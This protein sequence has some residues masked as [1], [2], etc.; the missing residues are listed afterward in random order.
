MTHRLIHLTLVA[1][2]LATS[3]HA[4]TLEVGENKEFK[5]PSGAAA[6]A[7][8]GD[9]VQ[10]QP[11]EYFDC[12]IWSANKLVVEGVGDPEK[13]VVTDKACQGKALFITVGEG[14]TIRNLTLTRARVPDG[15]GAGIR[16]EGKDLVVDGVRFVNNQNG[17]L[18]GTTGGSMVVRNSVFERNGACDSACAHGLYV[19]N[20]DLLQVEHSRFIG[21]KRGHHIKSRA[22]RTEIAG[23]TI[24]DGPEGT[25]SYEIEIPNGGSVL[26]RGNTIEKG[27]KAENHSSVIMI[28]AEGITHPTREITVENNTFRNDG[29]WETAFVNNLTA[30]EAVLR[31]NQLSGPVKPLRGDGQVVAGR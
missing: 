18:S 23:C 3:A 16:G 20:V 21:T 8:D 27:P 5:M 1:F 19:G 11:G 14:I 17:I 29:P 22:L 28:G 31:G 2:V 4:R 9:H 6:V 10:I 13:V 15:N 12:A 30:T 7:Q 26:V 25:A 24:E